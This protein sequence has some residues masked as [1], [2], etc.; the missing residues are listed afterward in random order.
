MTE[1]QDTSNASAGSTGS[2]QSAVG[3]FRTSQRMPATPREADNNDK[4]ADNPVHH[5]Q[6]LVR[7]AAASV[8]ALALKDDDWQEF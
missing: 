7:K 8:G 5:Q 4:P 3:F 2:A 1:P 6:G